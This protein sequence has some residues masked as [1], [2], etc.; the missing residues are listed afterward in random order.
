MKKN[1]NLERRTYSENVS[2]QEHVFFPTEHD[3]NIIEITNVKYEGDSSEEYGNDSVLS[4]RNNRKSNNFSHDDVK[5]KIDDI[6][7]SSTNITSSSSSSSSTAQSSITTTSASASATIS[8]A[9]T[10]TIAVVVGASAVGLGIVE[11]TYSFPPP[12]MIENINIKAEFFSIDY[13]F[14]IYDWSN[15]LTYVVEV[16]DHDKNLVVEQEVELFS[17]KNFASKNIHF[18]GLTPNTEYTLD[19]IGK[20]INPNTNKIEVQSYKDLRQ[21][22]T[23]YRKP[24]TFIEDVSFALEG[25]V[26]TE[27]TSGAKLQAKLNNC[28]S[29]KNDFAVKLAAVDNR[30][31]YKEEQEAHTLYNEDFI[32]SEV[33]A[34]DSYSLSIGCGL[35]EVTLFLDYYVKEFD[36]ESNEIK[37]KFVSRE[38]SFIPDEKNYGMVY[39]YVK[40]P[41]FSLGNS[42]MDL[43]S[44]NNQ[45]ANL[46]VDID[47]SSFSEGYYFRGIAKNKKNDEELYS[48]DYEYDYYDC[49]EDFK[50]ISI[51][52]IKYNEEYDFYVATYDTIHYDVA[53]LVMLREV[54]QDTIDKTFLNKDVLTKKNYELFSDVPIESNDLNEVITLNS[55]SMK[56]E[57]DILNE[58]L[59]LGKRVGI[60]LFKEQEGEY[61]PIYSFDDVSFPFVYSDTINFGLSCRLLVSDLDSGEEI[62]CEDFVSKI[63]TKDEDFDYVQQKLTRFTF[64]ESFNGGDKMNY[65]AYMDVVG[66]NGKGVPFTLAAKGIETG[67]MFCSNALYTYLYGVTS[68]EVDK[69]QFMDPEF[70]YY[71]AYFDETTNEQKIQYRDSR[72]YEGEVDYS[73]MM[74]IYEDFSWVENYSSLNSEKCT[75]SLSFKT[76]SYLIWDEGATY[77]VNVYS[78]DGTLI[79]QKNNL[80]EGENVIFDLDN[81]SPGM[82]YVEIFN[83]NNFVY[84]RFDMEVDNAKGDWG[85]GVTFSYAYNASDGITVGID[86]TDKKST[87]LQDYGY[88]ICATDVN[89]VVQKTDMLYTT[90]SCEEII[91]GTFSDDIN[92]ANICFELYYLGAGENELVKTVR[93]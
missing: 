58:N 81:I 31:L 38:D 73:S 40:G 35:N 48:F 90:G 39:G 10:V 91:Y 51:P 43:S 69:L 23:T 80:L 42:K 27:D 41:K 66:V 50:M 74:K 71:T 63:E 87:D 8:T 79:H 54:K 26:I 46:Y 82:Y 6:N 33:I 86:V 59:Y 92:D 78:L 28:N 56:L 62:Y 11:G 25:V 19:F 60:T 70:R 29:L 32:S 16:R 12:P 37:W 53:T 2:F 57:V 21:I 4:N 18:D 89:G 49:L 52:N 24:N 1:V 15:N 44:P 67:V 55:A 13:Q 68:F 93:Y 47:I 17:D 14:D 83:E 5:D 9:G 65:F 84:Q 75:C 85:Y 30:Y 64:S 36:K 20:A 34:D 72:K 61:Y 45:T 7:Q 76:N 77:G 88:K 3:P 22:V